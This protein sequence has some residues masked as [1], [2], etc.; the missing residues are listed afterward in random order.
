M[1][2]VKDTK[3]NVLELKSYVVR[4]LPDM[5]LKDLPWLPPIREIDFRIN[6]APIT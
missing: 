3:I 5:F 6:L 1:T 2:I 4:E